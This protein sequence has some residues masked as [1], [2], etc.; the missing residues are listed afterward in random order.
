MA[1][2][3]PGVQEML[4]EFALGKLV[5]LTAAPSIAA[6]WPSCARFTTWTSW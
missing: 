4:D 3:D 5:P 6:I 2:R 1:N